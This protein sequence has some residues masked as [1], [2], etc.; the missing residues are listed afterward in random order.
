[1]LVVSYKGTFPDGRDIEVK[2]RELIEFPLWSNG[3]S[4][5]LGALGHRIPGLAE[6]VKDLVLAQLQLRSKLGF[7]SVP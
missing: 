1:M 2:N 3:I 4:G 7:R 5:L 6:W